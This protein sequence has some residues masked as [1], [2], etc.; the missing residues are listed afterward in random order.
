MLLALY[1]DDEG[2]PFVMCN[3]DGRVS[4]VL[5]YLEEICDP[6]AASEAKRSDSAS[7]AD[8]AIL[9]EEDGIACDGAKQRYGHNS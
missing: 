2:V 1:L 5:L 7:N 9:T 6:A 3:S 4:Q 8:D